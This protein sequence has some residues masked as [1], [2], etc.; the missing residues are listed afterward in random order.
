MADFDNGRPPQ[1][2][3]V[4]DSSISSVFIDNSEA[5]ESDNTAISA[6]MIDS[7]EAGASRNLEINQVLVDKEDYPGTNTYMFL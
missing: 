1:G 7:G 4:A 3:N 2:T 5:T 6:V